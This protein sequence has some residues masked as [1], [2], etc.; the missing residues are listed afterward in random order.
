MATAQGVAAL[1]AAAEKGA[2][3]FFNP[4]KNERGFWVN[5]GNPYIKG[6]LAYKMFDLGFDRAYLANQKATA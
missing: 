6:T 2:N 5:L 3:A 1:N 4:I